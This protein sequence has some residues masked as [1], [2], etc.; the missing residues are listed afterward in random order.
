MPQGNQGRILHGITQIKRDLPGIV[1]CRCEERKGEH[2]FEDEISVC[3]KKADAEQKL[4]DAAPSL[5]A[6]LV[7][8]QMALLY[9]AEL[10][11]LYR[12]QRCHQQ[13]VAW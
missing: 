4:A 10:A 8:S 11:M 2:M 3:S 7:H 6:G 1:Y 13:S 12:R 5:E 9:K